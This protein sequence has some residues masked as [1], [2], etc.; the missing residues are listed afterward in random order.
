MIKVENL[1]RRY[2][3]FTA[4]D[5]ISF[6]IP[7]G[8]IVGFLGPN[9]AGK[10]TTLRILTGFLAPSE[11]KV[12]ISGLDIEDNHIEIKE[13][14]GYLPENNP[15]YEDM[16]VVDYLLWSGRL[17]GLKG[18]NLTDAIKKTIEICG[19]GEVIT[20]PISQLSRG[21]CQRTAIANTIIHN[22]KVLFLDEPTSGLDPNQA[23]HMRRLIK[24]LGREKTIMLSTH[25]LTEAKEVCDK[26]IIINKGKIAAEG[27]S[28]SLMSGSG[29]EQKIIL[30]TEKK[31]NPAELEK[32]L[33]A[34]GKCTFRDGPKE[35]EFLIETSATKDLRKDILTFVINNKIPL[36][37]FKK[38]TISLEELF[39][40]LTI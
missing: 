30:M 27:D 21:Y 33:S 8:E 4:V 22:P 11:G 7:K 10:T 17:K 14:L 16:T 24:N 18:K 13:I 35:Y 36:L 38:E 23:R 9:G 29:R 40:Q 26:I 28:E 34:F 19:I 39:R 25:I 6:E 37:E 5:N 2:G 1:T 32:K 20:K 31:L 3:S 15:L 12:S